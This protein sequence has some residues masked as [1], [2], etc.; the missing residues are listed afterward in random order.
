MKLAFGCDACASALKAELIAYATELGHECFDCGVHEGDWN[1]Y[2]IFS[3][4]VAKRVLSGEAERGIVICGTGVGVSLVANKFKGIR[5]ALC[6]DCYTAKYT[7]LHNDANMLAMGAR[8]VGPE[9]AKMIMETFLDT[10]YE[11]GHHQ[12]RVD[13]IA[14]VER[15]EDLE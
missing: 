2:P 5:C 6:G 4:R 13:M 10:G 7:R 11:G 15:G 1:Q 12:L 9:L 8:V 3:A 14:A